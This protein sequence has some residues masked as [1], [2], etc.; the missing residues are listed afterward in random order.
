MTVGEILRVTINFS[1][2]A[3]SVANLVLHWVLA[4]GS[5][6]DAGVKTEVEDWLINTFLEEWAV[7]ADDTC[8]A[9]TADL[10]IVNGDGTVARDLGTIMLD[11]PGDAANEIV[12][13]AVAAF[14]MGDTD[15]PKT[16]GRKFFPFL[17][18]NYITDGYLSAAAM[19][20][21]ALL[22]ALYVNDLDLPGAA[23]L[24]PGVVSRV[25]ESF[26]GFNGGGAITDIPAYQR[27]RKPN[28]GS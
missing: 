21:L 13:A 27:R 6:G 25:T 17:A 22:F 28:V 12:P 20:Q 2:P 5:S 15:S 14:I 7:F 1:S 9:D 4:G 3:S 26:V 8:T 24:S 19:V 11:V 23:T 18:E 10:D 16:R